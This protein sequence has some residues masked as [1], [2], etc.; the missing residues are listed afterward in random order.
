[1]KSL[2][3]LFVAFILLLLQACDSSSSTLQAHTIEGKTMGTHY[4]IKVLL[5][6]NSDLISTLPKQIKSTLE[7][8]NKALSNWDKESELSIFNSSTST[9]WQTISPY[10]YEVMQEADTINQQSNGMFD[11]TLSPLINLWG[12]GPGEYAINPSSEV[13]E[14][15]LQQI[16]QSTLIKLKSEP[17]SIKKK[18]ANLSINLSAIAKGYGID[19]IALLLNKQNIKNYI[20]E[21]GGDLITQGNNINGQD[22]RVGIEKPNDIGKTVQSVITLHNMAIA[23]SGDYRNFYMKDGKRISHIINP[24][25][26]YPVS[27]NLA[28]VTVIAKTAMRAD[29]LATAFLVMG[30]NKGMKLADQLNI[31]AYFITRQDKNYQTSSSK[32]FKKQFPSL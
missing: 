2:L 17:R 6:K 19:Q 13:I 29:G 7:K 26:G 27:H 21:I 11:V 31:S 16:G 5:P 28:S 22:W 12:F 10:F 8:V 32:L 30:K 18:Q 3:S 25:S 9:D 23:T 24:I 1:M 20:V 14:T 15:A 4:T